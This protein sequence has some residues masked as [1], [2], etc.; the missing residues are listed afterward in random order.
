MFNWPKSMYWGD[1]YTLRW[2]RP[3]RSITAV[4]FEKENRKRVPMHV[5]DIES[6]IFTRAH[7]VMHPEFFEFESI[8]DY[9]EKILKG[10]VILQPQDRKKS[11]A[12]R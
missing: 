10:K 9:K 11:Y 7:Q 1:N 4:L 12:R 8:N 6:D 3:L 5:R 2:V